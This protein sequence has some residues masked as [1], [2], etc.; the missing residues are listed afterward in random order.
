DEPELGD[1]FYEVINTTNYVKLEP[2]L[3]Y[4]LQSIGLINLEGDRSTPACELY[5]LYFQQYFKKS[6]HFNN[7]HVERLKEENQQFSVLSSLDELT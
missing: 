3:A 1:A 4:K 5:R 2:S 7:T 6:E